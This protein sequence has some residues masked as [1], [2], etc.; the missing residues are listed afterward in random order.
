MNSN[1]IK[2]GLLVL[3]ISILAGCGGGGGGS[4]S[5][6][7]APQ[8]DP[9]STSNSQAVDDTAATLVNTPISINVTA[10]D[11]SVDTST[12]SVITS[13]TNGVAS[14][15]SGSIVY[16]PNSGFA[17]S[18]AFVYEVNGEAG[19][20]LQANVRVTVN[21]LTITNLSTRSL[22][23]PSSGYNS[24]NDSE[25][26]TD[27]LISPAIQF[28]LDPNSVS[29]SIAFT[30]DNVGFESG[31]LFIAELVD[32]NGVPVSPLNRHVTFCDVGL[33]SGLIPRRPAQSVTSGAW[34]IRLGTLDTTLDDVEF[35]GLELVIAQRIGPPASSTGATLRINPFL[36]ADSVS[37]TD[38]DEVLSELTD[39]AT[40]SN[41]TLDIGAV[42]IV[43]DD[44]FTEVSRNFS[45]PITSQLVL[46]GSADQ[47]NL[48][49]IEDFSGSGGSGLLGISGGL[50]GPFGLSS[51]F[52]G[53]LINATANLGGAP[54]TY[55]R[56]TAEIA[57]HEMGHFLGLYHTTERRFDP[58]DIIDDTPEYSAANDRDDAGIQ[59]V[60]EVEECPDGQNLM[61]WTTDL[62][63]N[64]EPLSPDQQE[65]IFRSPMAIPD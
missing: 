44:Q 54:G 58:H 21:S 6:S 2:Q 55:A 35:N 36:T 65:V 51:N 9:P 50:P 7:P 42:Q 5:S 61:F 11:V 38:I 16:T 56:N 13:P 1:N 49:F 24:V 46:L 27:V 64:K 33:C 29:F 30:G 62:S 57:L 3:T 41:L 31:S 45:N 47:I 34:S 8:P 43:S 12:L 18:D 17:G 10:N 20:T 37:E 28:D 26:G 25:L 63:G 39:I 53:V 32:S 19:S 59:E 48:F 14:I 4:S 60:A 22:T 15:N 23:I 52:N 40:A